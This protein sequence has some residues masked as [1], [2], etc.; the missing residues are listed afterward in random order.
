MKKTALAF[1]AFFLIFSLCSCEVGKETSEQ[2][3]DS[4]SQGSYGSQKT[5]GQSADHPLSQYMTYT[6][7]NTLIDGSYNREL[8]YLGGNLFCLKDTG[9]SVAK[10]ASDST[11]YGWNSYGGVEIYYQLNFTFSHGQLTDDAPLPWNHSAD[12]TKAQPVD[13]CE[14][15]AVIVQISH[16]LYTVPEAE[17]SN[18]DD[19]D[20]TST[21]WYVFF[22]KEDSDISYAI[23]LNAD[24]YS[25]EDT[26][27]LAQSVKFKGNA[28]S[29]EVK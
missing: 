7:P 28:F 24:Y 4:S 6:L 17:E 27:S 3:V 13:K 22:A 16:D 21:M 26:I 18:I 1:V 25:K 12:L 10:K 19:A 8:G 29:I 20:L 9:G 14:A 11:P 15:P 2:A 5:A 23:F